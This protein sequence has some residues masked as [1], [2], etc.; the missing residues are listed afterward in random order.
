MEDWR[1]GGGEVG[2][3]NRG[4]VWCQVRRFS[5]NLKPGPKSVQL[6]YNYTA[7]ISVAYSLSITHECIYQ[8]IVQIT[9]LMRY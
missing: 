8:L 3:E 2:A 6:R 7:Y 5:M 1:G 9:I 4:A